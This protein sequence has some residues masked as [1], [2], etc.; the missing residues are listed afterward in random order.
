MP[1]N[2]EKEFE[3]GKVIAAIKEGYRSGFEGAEAEIIGIEKIE[4]LFHPQYSAH[5]CDLEA[6][7]LV[8]LKDKRKQAVIDA[9]EQLEKIPRVAYAEPDCYADMFAVPNDPYYPYLW[10]MT[11]IGAP[12]AWNYTMGS[13]EVTIGVVDSGIDYMHPDIRGNTRTTADGQSVYAWDFSGHGNPMDTTGHGT[14][15]AGT[16]GAVGNN[17]IGV[18]GVCWTVRLASMK[19]G[20][21]HFD[22]APVIMAIDHANMY[23]I[24]I[25]NN[26]WGGAVYSAS[27]KFA[28][29]HYNGLFIA[30]AGNAGSNNDV[31]PI[32]PASYNSDNI[33]S[34]A[35]TNS[36]GALA[37]FSNYGARSVDIAAPG[38]H[39]LSTALHGEYSYM[40]G[41]SMAAPHVAGAAALLKAYRPDFEALEIKRVILESANSQGQFSGKVSTNGML[42]IARMLSMARI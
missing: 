11:Q 5:P 26:S 22:I 24:P 10:G 37:A 28:I 25:L 2:N 16:I 13:A 38:E 7:V 31:H 4:E 9:I 12:S 18:A 32:Y 6:I 23:H 35:A 39:I 14:H 1:Y 40:D 19:I 8:H 3:S 15:A 42:D 20:G 21:Y 34:V 17:R 33:I 29:D 27:L 41:T 30:A 36:S